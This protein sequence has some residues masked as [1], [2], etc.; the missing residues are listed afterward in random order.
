M[1]SR[2]WKVL[3]YAVKTR[4]DSMSFELEFTSFFFLFLL[5]LIDR[6]MDLL[7]FLSARCHVA[8]KGKTSQL[9]WTFLQVPFLRLFAGQSGIL[10]LT[11]CC[12]QHYHWFCFYLYLYLPLLPSI[13]AFIAFH[14]SCW[15]STRTAC[16]FDP[17]GFLSNFQ[18][19]VLLFGKT[20]LR[21]GHLQSF[22]VS[23]IW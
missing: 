18:P 14:V 19:N 4:S 2:Q 13:A 12:H 3:P 5:H 1:I 23:L 20:R 16:P 22:T 15:V 17:L 6:R 10:W 9:H 21:L 8:W 11:R 7:Q